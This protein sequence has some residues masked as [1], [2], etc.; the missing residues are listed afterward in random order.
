MVD[1]KSKTRMNLMKAFEGESQARNRY[2]FFANQARRE[3]LDSTAEMFERLAENEKQHALFWFQM[4][5]DGIAPT[6]KNLVDAARFEDYE[7]N[8]MYLDFAREAREEGYDDIAFM[9]EK[10]AKI[11]GAHRDLLKRTSDVF[12][13]N[14]VSVQAGW[15][16]KVCGYVSDTKDMPTTCPV[17]GMDH[18]FEARS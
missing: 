1:A 11:E 15:V 10:V 13:G 14:Q 4:L 16:C 6:E 3:G 12:E 9:M 5:N 8:T 18:Q 17:C 7:S 2:T